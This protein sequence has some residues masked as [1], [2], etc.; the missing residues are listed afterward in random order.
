MP[1]QNT[2]AT[3]PVRPGSHQARSVGQ[4]LTVA[5]SAESEPATAS[6][7]VVQDTVSRRTVSPPR[8]VQ[9]TAARYVHDVPGASGSASQGPD[10]T[11]IASTSAVE[12]ITPPRA[13]R[14]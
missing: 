11:T 9:A 1:A 14:A 13:S 2:T 4:P 6:T 3:L 8:A 5:A 12:T 10:P 7:V